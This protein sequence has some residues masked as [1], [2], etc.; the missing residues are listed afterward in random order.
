[1]QIVERAVFLGIAKIPWLVREAQAAG[2]LSGHDDRAQVAFELD[3]YGMM[4]NVGFVLHDEPAYLHHAR[5]A[6]NRRLAGD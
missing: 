5:A 6:I 1:M 3:A 4:G 2:S